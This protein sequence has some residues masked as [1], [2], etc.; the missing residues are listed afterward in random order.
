VIALYLCNFSI[1]Y[2]RKSVSNRHII[3]AALAR[4]TRLNVVITERKIFESI[5]ASEPIG[6]HVSQIASD[7]GKGRTLMTRYCRRLED[8]GLICRKNKQAPYH[9]TEKAYSY[10]R[11][12]AFSFGTQAIRN[13]RN[14]ICIC[15]ANRFCTRI[16]SNKIVSDIFWSDMSV[17]NIKSAKKCIAETQRALEKG[18]IMSALNQLRLVDKELS[19]SSERCDEQLTDQIDLFEFA[20]RIGALIE[21]IMIQALRPKKL[22][23]D[24]DLEVD[25]PIKGKDKDDIAYNWVENAIQPIGILSEFCRLWTVKRGLPTFADKGKMT[26]NDPSFPPEIQNKLN[27]ERKKMRKMDIDDPY[28]SRHE[29]D[30]E[31]FKKLTEA[32]ANTYPD[33][34]D[35]LEKLRKGLP[36]EIE[37]NIKIV[38]EERKRMIRLKKDDPD[39]TKYN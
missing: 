27:A 39:H 28:W 35:E 4:L 7:I 21:Y 32:F 37:S 1:L 36:D 31:N 14:L 22:L 3:T 13:I 17:E 20:T 30:E 34:Y 5:A 2:Y 16:I 33:I 8:N 24:N 12:S 38:K 15:K 26:Y 23:P 19:L 18:D 10:P 6:R 11:L 25:V 29:M 9:I